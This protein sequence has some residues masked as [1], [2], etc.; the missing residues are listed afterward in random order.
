MPGLDV[1]G[2]R[3]SGVV[4]GPEVP[5]IFKGELVAQVA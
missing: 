3:G 1:P 5:D 2:R 4:H